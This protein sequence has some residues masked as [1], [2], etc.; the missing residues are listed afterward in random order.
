LK[1]F[2]VEIKAKGKQERSGVAEVV[3][4]FGHV[5]AGCDRY[6]D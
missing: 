2:G 6:V 1:C 5:G 4:E 3:I